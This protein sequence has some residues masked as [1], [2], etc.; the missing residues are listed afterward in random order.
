MRQRQ[1]VQALP[2]QIV[3]TPLSGFAA[4][5]L[6]SGGD[7]A[8]AARRLLLGVPDLGQLFGKVITTRAEARVCVCAVAFYSGN[9]NKARRSFDCSDNGERFNFYPLGLLQRAR[10]LPVQDIEQEPPCGED[11]V[12]LGGSRVAAQGVT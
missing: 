10:A 9:G 6:S 2:R 1:E 5:P 12:P 3:L 11:V 7:D 8:I 4:S